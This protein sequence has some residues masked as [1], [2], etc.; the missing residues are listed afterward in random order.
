MLV[1]KSS[2]IKQCQLLALTSPHRMSV[3]FLGSQTLLDFHRV[4]VE[5]AGDTLWTHPRH[6]WNR[7]DAEETTTVLPKE[8][9]PHPSSGYFFI[10]DTFYTTS[11]S[12]ADYVTPIRNWLSSLIPDQP[13][14]EGMLGS[15]K[16]QRLARL[17]LSV[18]AVRG[19]L[20]VAT[21]SETRLE[22]VALRLGVRYVHVHH[23][24]VE[25]SVFCVDRRLV[26]IDSGP[27]RYPLLHDVWTLPYPT[28]A[29]DGCQHRTP[30]FV[31][32]PACA[33]TDGGP[34][35]LCHSCAQQLQVP[36]SEL[37]LHSTYMAN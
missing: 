34:R 18:E 9:E 12:R 24:S 2:K 8:R 17:G 16:G 37:E 29:C 7:P 25:C 11:D 33:M 5:M 30:V 19:G 10:E 3:E 15:E 13:G 28:P 35:S 21:M 14:D 6:C 4:L 36:P 32:A 27:S 1:S 23:G 22:D 20:K 31:T 26:A